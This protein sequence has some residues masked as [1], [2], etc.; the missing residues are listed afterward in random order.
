MLELLLACWF[1]AAAGGWLLSLLLFH[2]GTAGGGADALLLLLSTRELKMSLLPCDA[3][4]PDLAA[5]G[6]AL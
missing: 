6:N 5:R 3:S 4:E 1:D 2:C